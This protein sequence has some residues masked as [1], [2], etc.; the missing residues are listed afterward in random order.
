MFSLELCDSL[1][2]SN[3]A[4]GMLDLLFFL[5]KCI[6]VEF[7]LLDPP[8]VSR[9]PETRGGGSIINMSSIEAL[10]SGS[11]GTILPYSVS[12]GG[13]ITLS[14]QMAVH[15]GRDNIRVNCIAPG[16]IYTPMVTPHLDDKS[17]SLRRKIT[18]LGTEG[19]AW[20]VAYAALFLASE[21][22]RWVTGIT[23]PV[24]AGLL[25]A[26]PIS[27]FYYADLDH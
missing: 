22:S 11:L 12:K 21:E 18:P 4:N 25:A 7:R 16:F 3:T 13:V 14:T 27:A 2:C 17:R 5:R 26:A 19:T 9:P 23:L 10:R 15:H 20:D 1:S 24:D 8:L 6:S